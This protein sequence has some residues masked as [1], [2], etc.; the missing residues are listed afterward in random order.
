MFKKSLDSL[1]SGFGRG[2][3]FIK[4]QVQNL[5]KYI[6]NGLDLVNR[7]ASTVNRI[8]GSAEKLKGIADN[9]NLKNP[10]VDSTFQQAR[11]GIS[12]LNEINDRTQK[13]GGE[14]LGSNVF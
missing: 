7:G 3:S 5:P 4:K 14:I 12:K 10:A 8:A 13:I 9:N 1:K 11:K 6:K 2:S